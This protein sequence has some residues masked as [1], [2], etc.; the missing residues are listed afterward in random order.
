MKASEATYLMETL[1]LFTAD[2]LISI[3]VPQS[4]CG[5][6][7]ALNG[8]PF[9]PPSSVFYVTKRAPLV[10]LWVWLHLLFFNLSNQ[11]TP[12]AA[13]EDSQNK[14]WRPLPAGRIKPVEAETLASRI[15]PILACVSIFSGGFWPGVALQLLTYWYNHGGGNKHW[16]LRGIINAGGYM[17]FTLGAVEVALGEQRLELS[18]AALRYL[19]TIA[20]AICTTIHAMDIYDQAGD[21]RC[22]RKTLPLVLGELNARCIISIFVWL[23][24]LCAPFLTSS[25]YLA[26]LPTLVLGV[27]IVKRMLQRRHQTLYFQKGTFKL[28]CF[29]LI[30][31]YLQPL[32]AEQI[33][34]QNMKRVH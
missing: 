18:S 7:L 16:L 20:S 10:A 8:A 28:W 11:Q 5:I 25:P 27:L 24:S 32:W 33:K 34:S 21:R 29:W 4:I 14:P 9:Q 22:G 3:L 12:D 13:A 26:N 31:L 30:S 6:L 23:F 17:S 1:W 15:L 2:D 19:A